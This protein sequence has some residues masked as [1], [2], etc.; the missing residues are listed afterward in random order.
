[1]PND[2]RAFAEALARLMDD[3]ALRQTLGAAGRQRIETELAWQYCAPNLLTA[4]Q[5]LWPAAAD[6]RLPTQG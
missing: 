6:K 2:E 4:Y 3:E 1:M 5:K